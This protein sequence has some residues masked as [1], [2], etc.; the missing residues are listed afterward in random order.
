MILFLTRIGE[1][2]KL[3]NLT[4][5]E[6]I[7]EFKSVAGWGMSDYMAFTKEFINRLKERRVE[8]L[9]RDC[10]ES[11]IR[12]YHATKRLESL[13]PLVQDYIITKKAY[14]DFVVN[15]SADGD[16]LRISLHNAECKLLQKCVELFGEN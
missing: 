12:Q 5:D 15:N 10:I 14:H 8:Q 16:A 2:M 9:Q 1:N 6:L 3:D 4:N 13:H 7:E 11:D